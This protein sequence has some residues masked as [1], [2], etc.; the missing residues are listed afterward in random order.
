[1][2][3]HDLDERK[4]R[5]TMDKRDGGR[6]RLLKRHFR[7]NIDDPLLYDAV[8]NTGSSS[9]DAIADSIISMLKERTAQHLVDHPL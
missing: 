5:E 4:A 7:V 6:A 2:E 3:L 1:M 8:W 9:F